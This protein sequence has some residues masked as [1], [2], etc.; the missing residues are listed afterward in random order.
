DFGR[1]P[2][3]ILASTFVPFS[4]DLRSVLLKLNCP[5]R[6]ELVRAAAAGIELSRLYAAATLQ[7]LA[8]AGLSPA[9]IAAIGCH[10][11]TVRHRPERGYTIQV[12]NPAWLVEL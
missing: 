4:A 5:D 11:Q 6:D 3:A 12:V 8:Q 2:L 1:E 7:V 10:G 9:E